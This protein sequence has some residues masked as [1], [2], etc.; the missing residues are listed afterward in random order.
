MQ[1]H[2]R[3]ILRLR[4]SQLSYFGGGQQVCPSIVDAYFQEMHN[5]SAQLDRGGTVTTYSRC[6]ISNKL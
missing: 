2:D 5:S 1:L 3:L 6:Q 4:D